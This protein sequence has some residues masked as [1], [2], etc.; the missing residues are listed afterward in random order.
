WFAGSVTCRREQ[1]GGGVVAGIGPG[2]GGRSGYYGVPIGSGARDVLHGPA[3]AN[4]AFRGYTTGLGIV[5]VGDV[6]A[7]LT[8]R[9]RDQNGAVVATQ[10]LTGIPPHAYRDA[11]SGA[12]GLLPDGF[13]GTATMTD[14]APGHGFAAIVNETGPHGQF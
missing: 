6:T 7:D 4:N 14:I 2:G 3:I 1:G 12:P 11:Y 10:T 9:Y 5:N 8:I 13:A